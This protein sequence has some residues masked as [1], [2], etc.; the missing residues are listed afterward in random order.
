[1]KRSRKWGHLAEH[2]RTA[3]QTARARARLATDVLLPLAVEVGNIGIFETDLERMVTR[4]SPELCRILGFP[5]GT[6]MTYDEA[7]LLVDERD[8][9][10]VKAAVAEAVR[11]S[12]KGKWSIVHRV[13]HADGTARWISV[14]RRLYLTR[15]RVLPG[16]LDQHVGDI[17]VGGSRGVSGESGVEGC[18]DAAKSHPAGRTPRR[19]SHRRAS[20]LLSLPSARI[21]SRRDANACS[22]TWTLVMPAITS[23]AHESYHEFG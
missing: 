9:A 18:L 14:I 19:R 5:V 15:P 10:A 3:P 8:R 13:R 2:G 7:T 21:I 23:P 12:D 22:R 4:F 1:M 20:Q 6:E 16:L 11:A 17:S